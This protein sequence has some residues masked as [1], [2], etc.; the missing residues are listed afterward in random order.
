MTAEIM[1]SFGA[2]VSMENCEIKV[3]GTLLPP[4]IYPIEADWSAASYFYE[5]ALMNP[6]HKLPI[7]N[8]A[9]ARDSL[10]GDSRCAAIFAA[11]GVETNYNDDGSAYLLGRPEDLRLVKEQKGFVE[12]DL[13]DTPDLAP[14]LAVGL[15]LA[16]IGF[17]LNSVGHLRH[18]ETDR[19]AAL[20]TELA[21]LGYN[22]EVGENE[23]IWHSADFHAPA[24]PSAKSGATDASEQSGALKISAKGGAATAAP[25]I[26]T[27]HDHRMAMAF[28]PAALRLPAIIIENPDVVGKSFPTY[29]KALRLLNF[30]LDHLA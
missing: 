22:I 28:A 29:W 6:G 14:A 15:C 8:L 11:V 3:S 18:K 9:P 23:M 4:E 17:R 13:N 2:E 7:A 21:K 20:Q 10:Q 25:C 26:E 5:M 19:L 16:G 1:K 30:H 12:F 27:Y 24:T